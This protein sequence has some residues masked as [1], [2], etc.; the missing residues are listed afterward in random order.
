V[1]GRDAPKRVVRHPAGIDGHA[2]RVRPVQVQEA[3]DDVRDQQ[4]DDPDHHAAQREVRDA[5]AKQKLYE[6]DQHDEVGDGVR[7]GDRVLER[8]RGRRNQRREQNRRGDE[9][10][11]YGDD[12]SVE[13][14][15][16]PWSSPAAQQ[17]EYTADQQ[18]IRAQVRE[19][20]GRWVR[21]LAA[22]EPEI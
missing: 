16:D 5:G 1:E 18:R 2:A 15:A 6:R 19:V 20:R 17:D 13:Q 11:R 8:A 21:R 14:V 9:R 22:Q 3:V 7:D 4:G 12:G 10:C